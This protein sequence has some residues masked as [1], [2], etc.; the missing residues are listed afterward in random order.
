MKQDSSGSSETVFDA[1]SYMVN[2]LS[3]CRRF[4]HV[5]RVNLVLEFSRKIYAASFLRC[6]QSLPLLTWTQFGG[7]K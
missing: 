3:G 4:N 5:Y 2:M 6:T 1:S 7:V